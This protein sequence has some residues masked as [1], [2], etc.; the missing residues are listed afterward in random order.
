M[1]CQGTGRVDCY[2]CSGKGTTSLLLLY[3]PTNTFTTQNY[4]FLIFC[5][6]RLNTVGRT[7]YA[8]LAILPKGEWPKWYQSINIFYSF[9]LPINI[10]H[11]LNL[12]FSS[13]LPQILVELKHYFC[14]CRTCGG[15]GLSYCSRCLGTGEYRYVMGFHFMKMGSGDTND[16]LEHHSLGNP[17]PHNS[18][19]S[20][21]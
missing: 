7:N 11:K 1:V 13:L 15:S 5:L 3:T 16:Q 8:Y 9:I 20:S 4:D 10:F 19:H 6:Y 12:L 2:H 18:A 17:G 21:T 14:R